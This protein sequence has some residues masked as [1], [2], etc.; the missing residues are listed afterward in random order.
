M[1]LY[2]TLNQ[3]IDKNVL[4]LL[5]ILVKIGKADLIFPDSYLTKLE[6]M[7]GHRGQITS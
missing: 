3:V 5:G 1:M 4:K 7:I 6:L 2:M